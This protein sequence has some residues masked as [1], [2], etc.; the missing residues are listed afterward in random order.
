MGV[1]INAEASL[2]IA[3]I[4]AAESSDL[5]VVSDFDRTLTK[6]YLDNNDVPTGLSIFHNGDFLRPNYAQKAQELWNYY[7]PRET[8]ADLDDSTK[9]KLMQEWYEKHV[10]L[11]IEFELN[12]S[13][14]SQAA[15]SNKIVLREHTAELMNHFA[16]N[17][18]PFLVFSAG[19]GDVIKDLFAYKQLIQPKVNICSNYFS[20]NDE[21]KVVGFSSQ[22]IHSY[23]KNK[24][25]IY[26][27][28]VHKNIVTKK[29][30]L[31]IG[32][33]VKDT[34]MGEHFHPQNVLRV[35]FCH[36]ITRL[37]EYREVFDVVFT[38][39]GSFKPLL[40]LLTQ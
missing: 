3:R 38:G 27:H 16:K 9:S 6:A 40:D 23:N 4:K 29:N 28:G 26:E 31:L 32:D 25:N 17:D 7:Y 39:D 37:S 19:S 33:S 2:K 30:L 20:F 10:S 21:Q 22:I 35:G 14:I 5:C 15:T 34:Q 36:N 8:R 11:F 13:I 24:I 12:K 18:I 1:Y